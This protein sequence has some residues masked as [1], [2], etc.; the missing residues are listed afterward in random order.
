MS[1]FIAILHNIFNR[2]PNSIFNIVSVLFMKE[3]CCFSLYGS[4]N[5][6]LRMT[7]LLKP[8]EPVPPVEDF[9]G[10]LLV[11]EQRLG[12]LHHARLSFRGGAVG[13][14]V[15]EVAQLKRKKAFRFMGSLYTFFTSNSQTSQVVCMLLES[16]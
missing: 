8:F 5:P 6:N 15:S 16:R 3:H 13:R 12:R 11:E 2:L 10:V 9:L 4:I 14:T 7:R 1:L